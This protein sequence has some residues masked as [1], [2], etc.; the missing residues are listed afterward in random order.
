M[1]QQTAIQSSVDATIIGD[2]IN[3][4]IEI[5][6]ETLNNVT[7]GIFGQF[8]K[9]TDDVIP[10]ATI[11]VLITNFIGV[12][13]FVNSTT[14]LDK[15]QILDQIDEIIQG[16]QDVNGERA[17]CNL[18]VCP[19]FQLQFLGKANIGNRKNNKIT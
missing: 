18:V 17:V 10:A 7:A 15:E 5:M 3:D 9:T 2:N 6:K 8:D 1:Y 12:R 14:I 11:E 13:T 4:Q 16:L 19:F